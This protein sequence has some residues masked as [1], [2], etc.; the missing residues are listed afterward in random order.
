MD[1]RVV[2]RDARACPACRETDHHDL[3]L[4]RDGWTIVRCTG[5]RFVYLNTVPAQEAFQDV[6]AW[7]TSHIAE[8]K[9]RK[10][11]QPI[12]QWI[13]AKTRWR[14]HW[15]PRPET[16]KFLIKLAAHGPVLDLGCGDGAPGKQLPDEFT[17]FGVEIDPVLAARADTAFRARG[18]ACLHGDAASV[19]EQFPDNYFTGVMMNS[20]LE[21]EY[22]P[23]EVLTSVHSKLADGAPLVIKV[24]NFGTVNARVMG[25]NWC[26]VRLPDHV[27]YFTWSSLKAM[28]EAVGY[29][30]KKPFAINTPFTDNMWALF[31]KA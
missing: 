7:N 22:K 2:S 9:R 17:P 4:S 1:Q 18:G 6:F 24:P 11:A 15:G 13:S 16:R 14:L 30:V 3:N 21:H 26:G 25:R 5:C 8:K 10:K 19:I 23:V 29:R 31:Y 27:N 12:L 28:G 20:Y